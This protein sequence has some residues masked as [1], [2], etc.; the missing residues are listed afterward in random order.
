MN[1]NFIS[2]IEFVTYSGKKILVGPEKLERFFSILAVYSPKAIFQFN[3]IK[4]GI[5]SSVKVFLIPIFKRIIFPSLS[6]VAG[7]CLNLLKP[8][9]SLSEVEFV[10]VN[11]KSRKLV[12]N[13][14][15]LKLEN[16]ICVIRQ[17]I[18]NNQY[19]LMTENIQDKIVI[20]AGANDGTFSI[21]AAFL[22]A[23]K[24]YAFEPVS[25]A[26]KKLTSNIK[27]NNFQ[28]KIEVIQKG[29]GDKNKRS[30]IF[31]RFF[32]DG[33]ARFDGKREDFKI[34]GFSEDVEIVTLDTFVEVNNISSVDFI[35]M[36]VEGFEE[37]VL[38][39]ALGTIIKM[40]PILSLAAYHLPD[41]QVRLPNIIYFLRDD[42][43]ITFNK[44]DEENLFCI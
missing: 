10:N 41:D 8:L 19:N 34:A 3:W 30:K 20:D 6:V 21:F 39:G 26:L 17:V 31:S 4:Y 14:S 7:V 43:K 13:T 2:S 28:N 23:K 1:R 22:G 42:Y 36:D 38:R 32:G 27:L 25:G 37:Q 5:F 9:Q 11:L 44:F 40:K 16:F 33:G 35:K 18:F 29:L 15:D 24:V 12:F